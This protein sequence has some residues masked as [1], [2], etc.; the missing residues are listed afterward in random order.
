MMND[1]RLSQ[2]LRDADANG[3]ALPVRNATAIA[4][5]A[6]SI[7][8]QRQQRTR[9][10]VTASLVLVLAV[11]SIAMLGWRDLERDR[12][13]KRHAAAVAL[14][15]EADRLDD[16]ASIRMEVVQA[17]ARAMKPEP[18][19]SKS[20]KQK[21]LRDISF[22]LEQERERAAAIILQAADQL[23]D[24]GRSDLAND[25][26]HDLISL[27]PDTAATEVARERLEQSKNRT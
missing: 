15:N 27:F 8:Q 18:K 22:E 11:G 4:I 23:R 26:Y 13:G 2:L 9:I 21:S 1:Q 12:T 19:R 20:T 6:R 5:A 16:E 10:T 14:R 7:R 24:A 25:R 17:V 3:R